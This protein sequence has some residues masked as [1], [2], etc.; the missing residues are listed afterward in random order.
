MFARSSRAAAAML[1][2][3]CE[4]RPLHVGAD[5]ISARAIT[6]CVKSH[7]RTL[8]APTYAILHNN[9]QLPIYK[10]PQ[11]VYNAIPAFLTILVMPLAYSIS[12]GIAIGII[13]WTL[14]NVLTGKAKEKNITPL[15]YVL[16]VLFIL[17]YIFL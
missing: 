15:M 5:S 9:P 2:G 16:T 14:I 1:P 10:H 13:S 17:K 11:K 7:G 6:D 3:R 8:F 12:E 4:H